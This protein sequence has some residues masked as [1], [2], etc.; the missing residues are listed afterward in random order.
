MTTNKGFGTA[1]DKLPIGGASMP[2][3]DIEECTAEPSDQIDWMQVEKLYQVIHLQLS[4]DSRMILKVDK[5]L[6]YRKK[7]LP[8]S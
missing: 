5:L 8:F 3:V 7:G 2:N 6:K 4:L 1:G